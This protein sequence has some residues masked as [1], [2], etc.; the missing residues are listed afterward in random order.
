MIVKESYMF[1][2]I[3][4]LDMDHVNL[5]N[6]EGN[7]WETYMIKLCTQ[8]DI[9]FNLDCDWRYLNFLDNSRCSN[10]WLE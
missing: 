8:H 7:V 9:K 10:H 2:Y 6:Q 4:E 1:P 5:H 3:T